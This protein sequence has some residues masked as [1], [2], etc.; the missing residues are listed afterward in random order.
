M[1]AGNE[2]GRNKECDFRAGPYF[3]E[4]SPCCRVPAPAPAAV[5]D[6]ADLRGRVIAVIVLV[7]VLVLVTS[8]SSSSSSPHAFDSSRYSI[9]SD[10]T[11]LVVF[12]GQRAAA[13]RGAAPSVA[14]SA[15]LSISVARALDRRRLAGRARRGVHRSTNTE[16]GP[17]GVVGKILPPT[18]SL[19]RKRSAYQSHR[20]HWSILKSTLS[21]YARTGRSHVMPRPNTNQVPMY[22]H[23]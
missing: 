3:V 17:T 15:P 21:S 22:V 11:F 5:E 18:G 2:H 20:L 23:I 9:V 19:R 8:S 7:L 12:L 1:A 14:T 4:A 10:A 16:E 13:R 6:A